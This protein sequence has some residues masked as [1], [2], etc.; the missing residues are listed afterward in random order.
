MTLE[1]VRRSFAAWAVP[2]TQGAIMREGI[3]WFD[4]NDQRDLSAKIERVATYYE[5][6]YGKRPTL[7]FVHPS[8]LAKGP[9]AVEG[10]EIRA[11]NSVLP[12]HCWIGT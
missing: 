11:T 1:G 6:R 9:A 3:L 12:N 7:C 5:S 2:L 8:D 4:N 10:I